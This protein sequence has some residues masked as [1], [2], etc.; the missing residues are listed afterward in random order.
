[1]NHLLGL[2]DRIKKAELRSYLTRNYVFNEISFLLS[3]WQNK[4]QRYSKHLDIIKVWHSM[5]I[6]S[7]MLRTS[8]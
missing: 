6:I 3:C 1:M 7:N 5:C 4:Q 8:R 2:C